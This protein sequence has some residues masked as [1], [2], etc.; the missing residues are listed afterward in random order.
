MTDAVAMTG[1]V[2][3]TD[4]GAMTDAESAPI[5]DGVLLAAG[6]S[7]RFGEQNK[8]LARVDGEPVVRHAARTLLDADLRS[9]VVVLGHDR[10]RVRETLS[11]LPV[12]TVHNPAYDEGQSTSVRT[13]IEAVRNGVAVTGPLRPDAVVIAL[14]DMPFVDPESV[15]ALCEAYAAGIGDVLAPAHDG[16]RGNPVLFDRRYFDRLVGVEGDVGG[17]EIIR[18]AAGAALVPVEDPGVRRDVDEPSDLPAD[19]A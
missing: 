3:M 10:D 19:G 16:R 12:H 5:V 2:A 17:R 7:S 18:S 15:D 14:G 4:G 1:A 13:G 11:D 9:V 6:S 8:L